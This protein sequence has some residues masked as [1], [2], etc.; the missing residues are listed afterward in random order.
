MS[1]VLGID[2]TSAELSIGLLK[3]NQPVC[4][5]SRYIRN[6]HAEQITHAVRFVLDSNRLSAEDITHAGIAIGPGSFTGLRIGAA[7]LKGFFFS[8]DTMALPISS[9]HSVA[10]AWPGRSGSLVV[11]FD[12]RQG[13]VFA[14]TFDL[15]GESMRRTSDDALIPAADLQAKLDSG[16]NCIYDRLGNTRSDTFSPYVDNVKV[17]S[18]ENAMLQRGLAC[19]RIAGRQLDKEDPWLPPADILPRYMQESRAETRRKR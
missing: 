5:Y 19:A 18:V 15:E 8:R 2:T 3:D 9:L 4:G 12:A 14:A 11:A 13:Q 17:L 1:Y 16:A 6:S 7:F 10:E